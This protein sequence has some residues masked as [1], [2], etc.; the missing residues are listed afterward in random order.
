MENLLIQL[1]YLS[2]LPLLLLTATCLLMY[3]LSI[4]LVYTHLIAAHF[5]HHQLISIRV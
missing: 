3:A 2:L 5:A 1:C 4:R